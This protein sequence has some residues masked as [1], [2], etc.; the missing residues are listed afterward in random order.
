MIA[1]KFTKAEQYPEALEILRK[2][3]RLAENNDH[4]LS[5]TYNNLACYYRQLNQPKTSL[6]FLE[7]ALEIA[8]RNMGPATAA[9]ADTHLNMCAVLSQLGRHEYAMMNAN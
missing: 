2:G 7:K 4:G 3:E 5:M 9:K 8:Q 1:V 6:I